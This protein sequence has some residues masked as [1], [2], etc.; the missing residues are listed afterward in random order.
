MRSRLNRA[1]LASAVAIV[2]AVLLGLAE[3]RLMAV[4]LG[5]AVFVAATLIVNTS[6]L[7]SHDGEQRSW[8]QADGSWHSKREE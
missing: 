4:T 8:R 2:V 6:R 5:V 1:L 7:R 3:P